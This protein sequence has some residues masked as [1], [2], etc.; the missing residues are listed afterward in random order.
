MALIESYMT[1]RSQTVHWGGAMSSSLLLQYGVPQGSI[2][3]PLLYIIATI[4]TGSTIISRAKSAKTDVEGYAD[5]TNTIVAAPTW[6]TV[7]TST[8]EASDVIQELALGGGVPEQV[9]DAD[10]PI[11][12]WCGRSPR[13]TGWRRHHPAQ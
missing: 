7:K 4:A 8:T 1:G 9:Q 6:D 2:L 5:D 3:G 11:W 12:P 13:Y 10:R